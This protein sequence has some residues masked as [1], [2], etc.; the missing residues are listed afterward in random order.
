MRSLRLLVCVLASAAVA[1]IEPAPDSVQTVAHW[2]HTLQESASMSNSLRCAF[3]DQDSMVGLEN[4]MIRVGNGVLETLNNLM[5]S[6]LNSTEAG[7]TE[8]Q[9]NDTFRSISDSNSSCDSSINV[10]EAGALGILERTVQPSFTRNDS[11]DFH[12]ISNVTDE[13]RVGIELLQERISALVIPLMEELKNVTAM[14]LNHTLRMICSDSFN[15]Y[16][17]FTDF[18]LKIDPIVVEQ[19]GPMCNLTNELK[20]IYSLSQNLSMADCASFLPIKLAVRDLFTSLQPANMLCVKDVLGTREGNCAASRALAICE[21]VCGKNP[22]YC[23]AECSAGKKFGGLIMHLSM[24]FKHKVEYVEGGFNPFNSSSWQAES[25]DMLIPPLEKKGNLRALDMVFGQSMGLLFKMVLE[26]DQMGRIWFF[27]F[28][29]LFYGIYYQGQQK[30]KHAIV[31]TDTKY[32]HTGEFSFQTL[33]DA[34]AMYLTISD[35]NFLGFHRRVSGAIRESYSVQ[36]KKRING[37]DFKTDPKAAPM[38]KGAI[39]SDPYFLVKGLQPTKWYTIKHETGS[40]VDHKKKKRNLVMSILE[41]TPMTIILVVMIIYAV[42]VSVYETVPGNEP[43]PGYVQGLMIFITFSFATEVALRMYAEKLGCKEGQYFDFFSENAT[44]VYNMID[45]LVTLL[46]LL[47]LILEWALANSNGEADGG[48]ALGVSTILRTL[49][50]VRLARVMRLGK[51]T[52]RFVYVTFYRYQGKDLLMVNASI[53]AK[54]RRRRDKTQSRAASLEESSDHYAFQHGFRTFFRSFMPSQFV[55]H[56][57]RVVS[58]SSLFLSHPSLLSQVRVFSDWDFEQSSTH[59]EDFLHTS[60]HIPPWNFRGVRQILVKRRSALTVYIF[61]NFMAILN[62]AGSIELTANHN[63]EIGLKSQFDWTSECTLYQQWI[64][65]AFSLLFLLIACMFACSGLISWHNLKV[66]QACTRGMAGFSFSVLY[67]ISLWPLSTQR[68]GTGAAAGLV[69]GLFN[70]FVTL[71]NIS[72]SAIAVS[73]A[74]TRACINLRQL[75]PNA[76]MIRVIELFGPLVTIPVTWAWFSFFSQLFA[77]LLLASFYDKIVWFITVLF[78]CVAPVIRIMHDISLMNTD[79]Q[80]TLAHSPLSFRNASGRIAR[81]AFQFFVTQVEIIGLTIFAVF[82][83]TKLDSL[84][85]YEFEFNT[86][87]CLVKD[88]FAILFRGG[89]IRCCVNYLA[90]LLITT[91][92]LVQFLVTNYKF[93]CGMQPY[94]AAQKLDRRTKQAFEILQTELRQL[95]CFTSDDKDISALFDRIEPSAEVLCRLIGK[96]VKLTLDTDDEEHFPAVTVVDDVSHHDHLSDAITYLK[97]KVAILTNVSELMRLKKARAVHAFDQNEADDAVAEEASA[98]T[99]SSG[100]N[101][102]PASSSVRNPVS[103]D[104]RKSSYAGMDGLDTDTDPF[105]ISLF[106]KFCSA[107]KHEAAVLEPIQETME[108][109]IKEKMVSILRRSH[110]LGARETNYMGAQEAEWANWDSSMGEEWGD[111]TQSI[112]GAIVDLEASKPAM[113]VI[114]DYFHWMSILMDQADSAWKASKK[115]KNVVLVEEADCPLCKFMSGNCVCNSSNHSIAWLVA[116]SFF[117]S[118]SSR[119]PLVFLSS[120]SRLPLVFL[121]SSRLPLI[122]SSSS[123]LRVWA[124]S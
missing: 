40:T 14:A 120:S 3:C 97:N 26:L 72:L 57:V 122:F 50:F 1:E 99:I 94:E 47:S 35:G 25:G 112:V 104:Q 88:E 23:P 115:N 83:L 7:S 69:A 80:L 75:F 32:L 93:T 124:S 105:K 45:L 33:S 77:P 82:L 62:I 70:A 64:L 34:K 123:H 38:V 92:I 106:R 27:V 100:V 8:V 60:A 79:A 18:K 30:H 11:I 56:V 116:I 63:C 71:V 46:D 31:M 119:L 16:M 58:S 54:E 59:E 42:M 13:A 9:P 68:S 108:R 51:Y 102:S 103:G 73:Q 44:G 86:F 21:A 121:S 61:C 37:N 20:D 15:R 84:A 90:T 117:L 81:M 113:S 98:A 65:Q 96:R 78:V 74:I 111:Q 118:S 6:Q 41:G 87:L 17:N 89:V 39:V 28:L 49:R 52:Q 29:C 91:D 101:P 36:T 55:L 85:R 2:M 66:S 110:D 12:C 4:R 10:P 114:A 67:V 24:F 76:E 48:G 109:E 19:A 107:D 53:S 95:A 5:L 22:F 43:L